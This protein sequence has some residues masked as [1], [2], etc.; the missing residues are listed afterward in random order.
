MPI[1]RVQNQSLS[2]SVIIFGDEG[3]KVTFDIVMATFGTVGAF[4]E[5]VDTWER[6]AD[7]LSQYFEANEIT[8]DARKRAILNSVVGAKTYATFCK[9]MFPKKP[10]ECSCKEICDEMQQHVRPVTS[11]ICERAKFFNRLRLPGESVSQ[12]AAE[13]KGLAEKCD[14]NADHLKQNLRDRYVSGLQD[15]RL[16]QSL[17][18]QG[19]DLTFTR[20]VELAN[21]LVLAKEQA[22]SLTQTQPQDS[23]QTGAESSS[24]HKVT[25]GQ[26]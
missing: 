14:Y 7:R 10:T 18:N 1:P 26:R 25:Q 12:Y 23:S 2:C 8:E 20:A 3:S 21:T 22:K 15:E 6:Y 11:K 4:E 5:G 19:D 24:V 9:I 17:L 16:M 13:L